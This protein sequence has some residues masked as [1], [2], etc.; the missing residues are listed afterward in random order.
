MPRDMVKHA[1]HEQYGS[2]APIYLDDLEA[3]R[4]QILT[5]EILRRGGFKSGADAEINMLFEHAGRPLAET[6]QVSPDAMRIHLEGMKLLLRK[7]ERTLF[8]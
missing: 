4:Q 7:K 5:A 6:F 3:R 8:D 2:M 1:W